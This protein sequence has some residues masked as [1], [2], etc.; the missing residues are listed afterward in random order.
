MGKI[1]LKKMV[2]LILLIFFVGLSIFFIFFL[3]ENKKPRLYVLLYHHIEYSTPPN[4]I[5]KKYN[6]P[7]S[8]FKLHMK[9]LHD[10]KIKIISIEDLDKLSHKKLTQDAAL[11]TFDDG[12]Q[13]VYKNALP[14][15]L[16]YNFPAV[17]FLTIKE[18][19]N[20][21]NTEKRITNSQIKECFKKGISIQSHGYSHLPLNILSGKE[22]EKEIKLPI[23]YIRR[24][25]GKKPIAFA[26]PGNYYNIHLK[27]KAQEF[28]KFIF[29]A[30]KGT[31]FI[32]MKAPYFRRII[33]KNE[34]DFNRIFSLWFRGLD[35]FWGFILALPARILH[36]Y[37]WMKIRNTLASS[38]LKQVIK[39]II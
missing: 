17:I 25:I 18:D 30:D 28:Y 32:R 4:I 3:P 12:Y 14:V 29:L 5:E 20:V 22:L 38:F 33:I 16:R 13:C 2:L 8:Q 23:I 9:I 11:I 10:R 36:P 19:S 26:F 37:H 24:L 27:I 21:F 31:E 15:L 6:V 7:P 35:R 1:C 34:M 39:Y